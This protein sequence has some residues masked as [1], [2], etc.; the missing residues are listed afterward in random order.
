MRKKVK[1]MLVVVMAVMMVCAI[2]VQAASATVNLSL[3]NY[4][5]Y[6]GTVGLSKTGYYYGRC[7]A[8]SEDGVYMALDYSAPGSGWTR[9]KST[10]VMPGNGLSKT[11]TSKDTAGSW[12]AYIRSGN[13][14]GYGW[15]SVST[16]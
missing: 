14:L 11:G 4:Q 5:A 6:T 12:R 15:V 1:T 16:D 3:G 10:N 7:N 2:A 13:F 9:V 8:A